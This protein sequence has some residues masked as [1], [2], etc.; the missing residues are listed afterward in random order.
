MNS[1]K[2][3][4]FW[5]IKILLFLTLRFKN[6]QEPILIKPKESYSG[7]G[8]VKITNKK[9]LKNIKHKNKLLFSEFIKGKHYSHS[10]F[11]N[12]SKI[13]SSYFVKEYCLNYPYAVDFSKTVHCKNNISQKKIINAVNKLI[14]LLKI[15]SGLIHTQYIVNKNKTY[16][17]E[18][19]RRLPGDF[20]NELIKLSFGNNNYLNNYINNFTELKFLIKKDKFQKSLR[21][22]YFINERVQLKKVIRNYKIF[23]KKKIKLKNNTMLSYDFNNK[24]KHILVA[25]YR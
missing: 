18:V 23:N 15:Q 10:C 2:K 14:K 25:K 6:Q 11:V 12:N 13:V 22:N 19:T 3:Q 8:I 4:T 5:H 7:I 24:K 1:C 20:Y 16:L 9:K 21:K 17:L